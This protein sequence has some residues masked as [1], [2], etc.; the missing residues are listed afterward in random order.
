MDRSWVGDHEVF[1][2]PKDGLQGGPLLVINGGI[3]PTHKTS[4][5]RG[6]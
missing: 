5:H 2:H 4:D 3:T 1:Q 6:L